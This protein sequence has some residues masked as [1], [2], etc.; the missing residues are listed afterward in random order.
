MD[1]SSTDILINNSMDFNT[2]EK[3]DV[4]KSLFV[5]INWEEMLNAGVFLSQSDVSLY[6]TIFI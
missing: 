2:M 1:T 4:S 6:I 3:C 5:Q